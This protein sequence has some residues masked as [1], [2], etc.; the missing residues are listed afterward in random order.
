MPAGEVVPANTVRNCG[1]YTERIFYF[2]ARK[3]VV[4]QVTRTLLR[5]AEDAGSFDLIHLH[6]AYPAGRAARKLARRWNIPL[7]LTEHWTAYH[8]EQRNAVP[9]WRRLSMRATG[10]AATPSAPFQRTWL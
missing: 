2:R 6:V 7:V 8:S 5:A 10:R 9:M 4:W 3:P 1:T